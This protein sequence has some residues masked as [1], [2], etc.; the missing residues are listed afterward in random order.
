[1]SDIDRAELHRRVEILKQKLA[2]GKL[3]F[4]PHLI[5]SFRQSIE[6]IRIGSDGLVVPETVDTRVRGLCLSLAFQHDRQELK[7]DVPLPDIQRAYFRLVESLFGDL[8][9]AM[10]E[11]KATP[12]QFAR[13]F[14]D[15]EDHVKKNHDV[16]WKFVENVNEFW[17][18]AAEPTWAHTEDRP[19]LI[20]TILCGSALS[21]S[22]V[23]RAN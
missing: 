18:N 14:A 12:Y 13:W 20:P 23:S 16:L 1:M 11:K 4:A 17:D 5:E 7:E 15:Q 9:K 10:R 8:Y 3:H 2:E 21:T 19:D 6:A 22:R